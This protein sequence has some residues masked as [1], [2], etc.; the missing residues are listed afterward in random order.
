MLIWEIIFSVLMIFCI[1]R[2]FSKATDKEDTLYIVHVLILPWAKGMTIGRIL[3]TS[4]SKGDIVKDKE[5]PFVHHEFQHLYQWKK[6][7]WKFPLKY[8]RSSWRAFSKRQRPYYDNEYEIQAYKAEYQL[9]K[10][11][12]LNYKDR[13]KDE[14]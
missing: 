7:G 12:K 4:L 2:G 14:Y 1:P 10:K 9:R 6:E 11:L 5:Q 3:F 8:I 13:Y